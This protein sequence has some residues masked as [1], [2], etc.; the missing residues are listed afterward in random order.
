M[1]RRNNPTD[2]AFD[3]IKEN[4]E[5][6]EYC[7]QNNKGMAA[8]T[9]LLTSMDAIGTFYREK[10]S[11]KVIPPNIGKLES[12]QNEGPSHMN[13]FKNRFEAQVKNVPDSFFDKCFYGDVRSKVIHN[14]L[15]REGYFITDSRNEIMV[16]DEEVK[17]INLYPL[18]RMVDQ[19]YAMAYSDY[20]EANE[21]KDDTFEQRGGV[22]G[23]T[24][25]V[26]VEK[27]NT[28]TI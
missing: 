3:S 21:G 25:S 6:C 22:T 26:I 20:R 10:G 8:F 7:L 23:F 27:N 11:F 1:A 28:K 15:M 24:E 19:C 18:Y 12:D 4:L 16:C 2:I 5:A 17:T 13:A 9:L 14:C